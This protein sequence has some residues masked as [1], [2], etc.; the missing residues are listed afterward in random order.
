MICTSVDLLDSYD[1]SILS[2][3]STSPRMYICCGYNWVL[4]K[5][6]AKYGEEL[7]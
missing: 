5:H 7:T 6:P 4:I 2:P 3:Q 1:D